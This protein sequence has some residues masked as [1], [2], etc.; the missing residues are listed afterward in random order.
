MKTYVCKCG[1]TFKKSTDAD[2][3]GYELKGYSPKHECYGCPYIV[4]NRDWETEEITKYTCRATPHITY[5]S[6][7]YIGTEYKDFSACDLYTLDIDFAERVC[8]FVRQQPGALN[9]DT[10]TVPTEWRNSDFGKIYRIDGCEGLASIRL[11]FQ[12]NKLGTEARRTVKDKF[13]TKDGY[14]KDMTAE[15][16]KQHILRSIEQAIKNAK[17]KEETN[18]TTSFDLGAMIGSGGSFATAYENIW[19]QSSAVQSIPLSDIRFFRKDDKPQPY[20]IQQEKVDRIAESIQENGQFQPIIIRKVSGNQQKYEILAGHHRYLALKQLEH[21]CCN[22]VI[23]E[24][25]DEKAYRIVAESNTP[26]GEFLPS[27][28][29][30]IY[31]EYMKMRGKA[32][33]EKTAQEIASKFGVGKRSL[34]RYIQI[35]KLAVGLIHAIDLKVIP[36]SCA[37]KLMSLTLSQQLAIAEYIDIYAPK[38]I[39]K[40]QLESICFFCM[41]NPEALTANKVYDIIHEDSEDKPKNS[42]NLKFYDKIKQAFPK[43]STCNDSDME[44]L[45]FRLLTKYTTEELADEDAV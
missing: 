21:Q 8:E 1:R 16:E 22:A 30:E 35:T 44:N 4:K 23:V 38:K 14:R 18:M 39:S 24:C 20:R 13:F 15:E 10:N 33:E 5:W 11:T 29:G 3:T 43:L 7:C 19:S 12:N 45:I 37:D 34:Y 41:E 6:C 42:S 25:D 26:S 17:N 28:Q 27:E 9:I 36:L 40:K 31:V 32:N 2:S